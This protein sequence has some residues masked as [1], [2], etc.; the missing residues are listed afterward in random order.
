MKLTRLRWSSKWNSSLDVGWATGLL[1][2]MELALGRGTV[3]SAAISTFSLS[4]SAR[5]KPPRAATRLICADGSRIRKAS[6]R[7]MAASSA[8]WLAAA[9]SRPAASAAR[10]SARGSIPAG[11]VNG[12][13]RPGHRGLVELGHGR[14]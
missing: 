5:K 8:A 9:S 11:L 6:F 7:A 4:T 10:A 1:V 3:R 14:W 12:R 13:F 2:R